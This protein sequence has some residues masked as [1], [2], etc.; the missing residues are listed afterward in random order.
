MTTRKVRSLTRMGRRRFL[1]NAA[2][3][4]VS[5]SALQ[6]LSQDALAETMSDADDEVL[7]LDSIVH[8]E[9][10][11]KQPG[12]PPERE[13]QYYTIPR[14]AWV[15]VESAH[16]ARRQI[17]QKVATL[18][19][20]NPVLAMV[21]TIT[22]GQRRKKAVKVYAIQTIN[23]N[24]S[25]S[26]AE[27]D[28]DKLRELL[29]TSLTGTAGRG[30]DHAT[31]VEGIPVIVSKA[32]Q[33]L[34]YYNSDYGSEVPGG[35]RFATEPYESMYGSS[36]PNRGT[37]GT[38]AHDSDN[39]TDVLVTAGHLYTTYGKRTE[40]YQPDYNQYGYDHIAELDAD[41][42]KDWDSYDAAV[43]LPNDG[44]TPQWKLAA[45]SGGFQ[46][47]YIDGIF[48]RDRLVD[49]EGN[50][51]Y[52]I[53]HQG[54]SSGNVDGPIT[55]VSDTLFATDTPNDG[56]DSGGPHFRTNFDGTTPRYQIAG[57][58]RGDWEYDT[59]PGSDGDSIATI[60]QEI[61]SQWNLTV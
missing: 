51:S 13:P 47:G 19:P 28:V 26:E 61:E 8:A 60:M 30:T 17:E 15:E 27:V 49:E 58:H 11:T 48:G 45:D 12:Q 32:Y 29:P 5:A 3:L 10:T 14:D 1:H 23:P 31:A 55:G 42:I 33:R 46:D 24:E 52:H 7:R 57:I 2:N 39:N 9:G 20:A 50:S 54:V 41:K 36:P 53:H 59:D 40:A 25:P 37:L 21:E 43:L 22:T 6:Y 34:Q 16:D 44:I 38:P 4:G 56:G 35:C 18:E